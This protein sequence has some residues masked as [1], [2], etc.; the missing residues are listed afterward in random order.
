MTNGI[1]GEKNAVATDFDNIC[2][3]VLR[4]EDSTL[5]G[6]IK[7]LGDGGG[8]TRFGITQHAHPE[9]SSIFWTNMARMDALETAK[10]VY[11]KEYWNPIHGDELPNDELASVLMDFSVNSG[12]SRAVKTLQT[13]LQVSSDGVL[14]HG[15]L[16]AIQNYSGDLVAAL[17]QARVNFLASINSPYAEELIKRAKLI[18]PDNGGL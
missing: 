18:Y 14:G 15:T 8:L 16:H 3:W 2:E 9:I 6:A 10:Q 1:F 17:R 4:F 7:N 5:S 13:I 11:R 12:M